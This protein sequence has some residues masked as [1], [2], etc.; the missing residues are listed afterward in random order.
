M[1]SILEGSKRNSFNLHNTNRIIRNMKEEALKDFALTS[2][3]KRQEIYKE[4]SLLTYKMDKNIA[5]YLGYEHP[6]FITMIRAIV[7]RYKWLETRKDQGEELSIEEHILLGTVNEVTTKTKLNKQREI[8]AELLN[9]QAISMKMVIDTAENLKRK[10]EE[11]DNAKDFEAKKK[12]DIV[13]IKLAEM[14]L[15][16]SEIK[17]LKEDKTTRAEEK[18]T[19]LYTECGQM[20]HGTEVVKDWVSLVKKKEL[21]NRE[22]EKLATEIKE[23]IHSSIWA[24]KKEISQNT[25]GRKEK[26][27]AINLTIW[28]I[29]N[30]ARANQIRRCF[31]YFGKAMI[32]GFMAGGKSKAAYIS[33]KPRDEKKKAILQSAWAIHFEEGKMSRLTQAKYDTETLQKRSSFKAILKEIPKSATESALLRQLRVINTK[34][35]YISKN[36][37]GNQRQVA[38]IYFENEADMQDALKRSIYY[39][40]TKLEWANKYSLIDSS[41][42]NKHKHKSENENKIRHSSLQRFATS[43]TGQNRITKKPN[44]KYNSSKQS[45]RANSSSRSRSITR[46]PLS[47]LENIR[48]P[49]PKHYK[50]GVATGSNKEA[51]GRRKGKQVEVEKEKEI[52][53]ILADMQEKFKTIEHMLATRS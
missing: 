1:R 5:R 18:A 23:D 9:N 34:A 4:Y 21:L 53:G 46:K 13:R 20:D 36:R 29:P 24:P 43:Q 39:Y 16:E 49:N 17:I 12:K 22:E 2:Q 33:L 19:L 30:E 31:S 47:S 14:T 10:R 6:E 26:P 41:K 52:M 40:N 28:D 32:L 48:I 11:D 42:E 45:S 50:V 37:N 25:W 3:A 51:L 7:D 8:P 15:N 44:S 38:T 35:V 27:E